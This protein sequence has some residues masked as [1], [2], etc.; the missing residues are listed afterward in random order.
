[1]TRHHEMAFAGR[2]EAVIGLDQLLVKGP[3][4]RIDLGYR[5]YYGAGARPIRLPIASKPYP[6]P[7]P[8]IGVPP[9]SFWMPEIT[10]PLFYPDRSCGTTRRWSLAESQRQGVLVPA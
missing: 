6:N 7:D 8:L 2:G 3:V 4:E 10:S 1:M 9:S 5:P